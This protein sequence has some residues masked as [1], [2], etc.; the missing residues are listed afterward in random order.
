MLF[1]NT[2]IYRWRHQERSEVSRYLAS[3]HSG[4]CCVCGLG[5]ANPGGRGMPAYCVAAAQGSWRPMAPPTWVPAH[6]CC[7]CRPSWLNRANSSCCWWLREGTGGAALACCSCCCCLVKLTDIMAGSIWLQSE[8][9]A[10]EADTG[11]DELLLTKP[12]K[13]PRVPLS[14][15]ILNLLNPKINEK[16]VDV[17]KYK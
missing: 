17:N 10:V 2:K 3:M 8:N 14:H 1:L 6:P 12:T 13:W 9:M 15:R 7:F 4:L 16:S 11:T 5:G